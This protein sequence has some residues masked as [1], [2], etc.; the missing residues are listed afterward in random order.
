MLGF[1]LRQAVKSF[2]PRRFWNVIKSVS[3]F[4][5]S[6]LL[7]RPLVW[8]IPPVITVE[9]TNYCNL[10]C[11]LCITGSGQMARAGGRME[12]DTFKKLIDEIGD[13]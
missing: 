13:T 6:I 5:S 10:D 8:G 1:I 4:A 2:T 11:P 7:K 9:P 12:L 3:S